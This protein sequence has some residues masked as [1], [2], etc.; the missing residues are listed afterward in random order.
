MTYRVARNRSIRD[1]LGR[2]IEAFARRYQPGLPTI[3]VLPGGMGSQLDR[4]NRRYTWD[5]DL[6]FERYDPIWMDLGILFD[7]DALLLEI[8]GS[9]KDVGD[10]VIIP[11]GPLEFLVNAYDGTERFL[12]EERGWNYVCFGFDWRRPITEWASYLETFLVRL[13]RR[14]RQLKGETPL[15]NTTLLCHSMGGLVATAFLN[16]LPERSSFHP[17]N[18]EQWLARV[19]TVGTPFYGTSTHI[20]RYYKG[21]DALNRIHGANT[22]A[23][24]TGSLPGPYVL[25]YPDRALYRRDATELAKTAFPLQRYPMRDAADVSIEVDPYGSASLARYPH[26]VSAVYL[27]QARQLRRSIT[28]PL[29]DE[30]SER[31]FHIRSGL[32]QMPIEQKWRAVS[33]NEFD[34]KR[35]AFPVMQSLKGPGD[36]TV[37]AWSARLVGT[38]LNHVY[39][40][41]RARNHTDLAEHRE[42]LEVLAALVEYGQL[43]SATNDRNQQLGVA[44]ASSRRMNALIDDV[45]HG[46]IVR[47]DRRASDRAVWRRFIEEASLC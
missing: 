27:K 21:Q 17:A 39:D 37:P 24:I 16:R 20:R 3:I 6:P 46:R 26:W 34:A 9:G 31:M 10:H 8:Q 15:P 47:N 36:G 32:V 25:L 41:K 2:R 1:A 40:L 19:V 42:T 14:V 43:P 44:K 5:A 30:L 12:R 18:I 33:G 13:G 38:P 29:P 22:V 28:K 45:V 4:S 35:S 23:R 11:D 7:N